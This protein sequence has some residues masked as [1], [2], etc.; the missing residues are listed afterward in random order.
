MKAHR[1]S[2]ADI[3]AHEAYGLAHSE[4]AVGVQTYAIVWAIADSFTPQ[5]LNNT[6]QGHRLM[7]Q[8]PSTQYFRTGG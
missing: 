1:L 4:A 3:Q 7:K 6:D 8:Y 2:H 5:H